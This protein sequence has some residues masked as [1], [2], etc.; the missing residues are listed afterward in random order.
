MYP[1]LK[2]YSSIHCLD[3]SEPVCDS[4]KILAYPNHYT[5]VLISIAS[6]AL[7]LNDIFIF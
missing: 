4:Y 5:K 7:T 6:L 1:D 2:K 3:Y